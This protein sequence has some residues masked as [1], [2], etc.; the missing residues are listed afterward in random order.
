MSYRGLHK[1]LQGT[2]DTPGPQ[3]GAVQLP[4]GGLHRKA[5]RESAG[6]GVKPWN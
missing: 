2:A 5:T 1:A 4:L 3:A 6:L